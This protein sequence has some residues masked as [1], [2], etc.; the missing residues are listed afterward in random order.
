MPPY[1][2]VT[3]LGGNNHVW[4]RSDLD[5]PFAI[6]PGDT[7]RLQ[8][9]LTQAQQNVIDGMGQMGFR[10]Y[11]VDIDPRSS[12]FGRTWVQEFEFK[13]SQYGRSKFEEIEIVFEQLHGSQ[14]E[15]LMQLDRAARGLGGFLME[16][17][18]TDESW[19]RAVLDASSPQAAAMSLQ[20]YIY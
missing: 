4:L 18:G 10:L 12:W 3:S 19:V 8:V 6:D 15:V 7:D 20:R 14:V 13:P 11:K 5:V 2:P 9:F 16:L 17:S 1:T